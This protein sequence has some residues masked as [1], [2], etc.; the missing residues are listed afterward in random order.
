MMKIPTCSII[1]RAYNEEQHIRRLLQGIGEQSLQDVQII[2]VD[3]GSTDGTL[4]ATQGYAVEVVS[5]LPENFTFGRSL[6][7]GFAVAR[8]D[9]VVMASAHVYPVYPDWLEQLLAPFKDPKVGLS[10]GKQRGID[11]SHFSEQ[12]IFKHWYPDST[13]LHQ[14]HPFCNNANAAV[15]RSLWEL[16]PYDE[17]LP[18]LEDLEWGKWA[19]EE[20]HRIA[21]V[22]EAEVIHVHGES[23][24]GIFNRYRREGMAFK[25][26]YPHERFGK[27][28]LI[29]LFYHN[30]IDDLKAA[31][32]QKVLLRNCVPIIKFRWS[33]FNGTY[34]GYRQ[35]GPLTWALRQAFY[36]PRSSS[37]EPGDDAKRNVE[38]IQYSK[39]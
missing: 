20:G 16:H 38:P 26:I 21:Y 32:Q 33:Q 14:A 15:R 31:Q 25:R 18:G 9:L 30:V 1:I 27:M 4:A 35:S 12:Q 2:L 23:Q 6:N 29:R 11:H 36:Y 13:D 34:H 8:S 24:H 22:A 10:Y 17:S 28:D 5:I 37:A 7:M 3:S 39:I 19:Q